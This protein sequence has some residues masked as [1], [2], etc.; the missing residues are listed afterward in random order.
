MRIEFCGASKHR[1]GWQAPE[2]GEI[3][4]VAPHLFGTYVVHR[5]WVGDWRVSQIETGCAVPGSD[6]ITRREAAKLARKRLASIT[7]QKLAAA[8]RKLP[9]W[10]KA[11]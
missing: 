5:N 2:P 7:P 1:D 6:A 4:D 3:V 11:A 10:V 9:A 8:I